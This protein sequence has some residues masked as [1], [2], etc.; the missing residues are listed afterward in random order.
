MLAVGR[1]SQLKIQ[2]FI[3]QLFP[4]MENTTTFNY[5]YLFILFH[6]ILFVA[7]SSAWYFDTQLSNIAILV[8]YLYMYS[9]NI[10]K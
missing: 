5:D 7:D 3:P 9:T 10:K 2:L 4:E 6:F 1:L 8:S